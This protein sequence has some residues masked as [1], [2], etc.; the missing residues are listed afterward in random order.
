[1][2]AGS[3]QT[4]EFASAVAARLDRLPMTRT[5]WR[6]VTLISLGGAFE[7]YELFLTGYIAPG[8]VASGIFANSTVGFFGLNGLGFFVFSNFAGM[9]LGCMFM[10]W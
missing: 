4:G 9:W 10:G 5:L 6:L 3:A 2:S 7:L 8:L 1:M